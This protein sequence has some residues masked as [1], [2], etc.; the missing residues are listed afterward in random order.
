MKALPHHR[1]PAILKDEHV[2]D[3]LDPNQEAENF[4]QTTEDEDMEHELEEIGIRK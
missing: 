3:W 1:M 4:L 2:K